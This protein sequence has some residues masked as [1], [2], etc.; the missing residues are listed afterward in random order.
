[1]NYIF[2]LFFFFYTSGFA[3]G[4]VVKNPP[5]SS[6]DMGLLPGSGRSPGGRNGNSLQYSCLGNPMDWGAWRV[7]V[8]GVAKS[9]TQ[10]SPQA[11]VL[12]LEN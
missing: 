2:T 8:H 6:G 3:S 5:A 12:D 7:T 11:H 10:L 1:M 9:W 4:T